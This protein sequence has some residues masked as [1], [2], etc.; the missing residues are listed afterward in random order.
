MAKVQVSRQEDLNKALR[1]LKKKLEED[2]VLRYLKEREHY[3]KPSE[4]KR[5]EQKSRNTKTKRN[6]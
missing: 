2:G 3:E 4:K 5:R 1:K 6:Y